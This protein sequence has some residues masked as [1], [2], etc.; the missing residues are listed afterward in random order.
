VT[1]LAC[2]EAG[3]SSILDSAEPEMM[4]K[5][6]GR[7]KATAEGCRNVRMCCTGMNVN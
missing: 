4:G 6:D 3:P 2:C 1:Q 7:T 5:Q